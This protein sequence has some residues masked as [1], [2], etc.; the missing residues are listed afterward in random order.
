VG[1]LSVEE[2]STYDYSLLGFTISREVFQGM[3]EQTTP[4]S[5]T[6]TTT[7]NIEYDKDILGVDVF[8]PQE[9]GEPYVELPLPGQ[10]TLFF[11]RGLKLRQRAVITVQ[12]TGKGMRYQVDRRFNT[13]INASINT[14]ELSEIRKDDATPALFPEPPPFLK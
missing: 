5:G 1:P 14:L 8:D 2:L 12:W 7:T 11:P 13:V 10:L 4:S 3:E 6:T 9:S